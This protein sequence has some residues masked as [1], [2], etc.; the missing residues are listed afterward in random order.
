[1]IRAQLRD[2]F[3]ADDAGFGEAGVDQP[4][5]ASKPGTGGGGNLDHP[6]VAD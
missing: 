3:V 5:W 4:S 6:A 2:R 1:M